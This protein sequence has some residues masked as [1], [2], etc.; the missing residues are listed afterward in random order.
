MYEGQGEKPLHVRPVLPIT[1]AEKP[2]LIRSRRD[3]YQQNAL[4]QDTLHFELTGHACMPK[5]LTAWLSSAACSVFL[6]Q[7]NTPFPEKYNVLVL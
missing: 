2:A 6:D 4:P 3:L 5:H 7:Q 1:N